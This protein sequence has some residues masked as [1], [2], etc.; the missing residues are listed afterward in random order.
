MKFVGF[1]L[2][3]LFG[4]LD[5]LWLL[6]IYHGTISLFLLLPRDFVVPLLNS[7]LCFL[8][9]LFMIKKESI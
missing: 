8:G 3:C 5:I 7:F 9:F 4:Y 1:V 2:F 6:D